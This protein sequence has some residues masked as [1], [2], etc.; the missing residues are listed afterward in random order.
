MNNLQ[1]TTSTRTLIDTFSSHSPYDLP[2]PHITF[3]SP[4]RSFL[5]TVAVKIYVQKVMVAQCQGI[6]QK[7]DAKL[8][9]FYE[10]NMSVAP[11][12]A[13]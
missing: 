6:S 7:S 5:Y 12:F 3:G 11:Q 4:S 1:S 2:L 10:S 9:S 13:I 8:R